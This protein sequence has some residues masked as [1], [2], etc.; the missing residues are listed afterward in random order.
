MLAEDAAD[1]KARDQRFRNYNFSD[2]TDTGES[3]ESEYIAPAAPRRRSRAPALFLFLVVVTVGAYAASSWWLPKLTRTTP[4]AATTTVQNAA[5]TAGGDLA[6]L[7]ARVQALEAKT[8]GAAS[9]ADLAALRQSLAA[10][11]PAGTG[12]APTNESLAN[13]GRQVAALTA[14]LSTLEAAIG[15]AARL[16]EMNKRLGAL[17]GKSAEAASVLALSDR[18]NA[19]ETAA[20]STANAQATAVAYVMAL[21]QWQNALASGRPF[22]LELETAKALARRGRG[23]LDDSGFAPFA[24]A[25]LP[26]LVEL[27]GRF[28]AAAAAA[29]RAAAVPDDTASWLRRMLDRIMSIATIRRVD[30]DVEGN[31]AWAIV[32]RAESRLGQNDL[33]GAVTEMESL[34]GSAAE[35]AA[36]WVAPA[37]ARVTAEHTLSE[38]TTKAIAAVAV[39]GDKT[40]N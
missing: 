33:T 35:A 38:A 27:R 29:V 24:A 31:S 16:D 37:R 6:T 5:P 25:G 19:L 32:A 13:R 34:R 39:T 11:P 7:T 8:A 9:T 21:G 17:E 26:T 22:A 1:D 2:T 18:V 36:S 14:R 3:A 12:D 20:R 4:V 23:A 40:S 30:G 15:N 10:Q 28:D